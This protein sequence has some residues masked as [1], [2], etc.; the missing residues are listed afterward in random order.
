MYWCL[1]G[2]DHRCDNVCPQV[3]GVGECDDVVQTVGVKQPNDTTSTATE[4]VAVVDHQA[5]G[6]RG[7]KKET[8]L[9]MCMLRH[10]VLP[11][12]CSAVATLSP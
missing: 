1:P 6:W 7:L 3:V 12:T 9:K 4:Q 5:T 10:V 8:A 2:G 11:Q